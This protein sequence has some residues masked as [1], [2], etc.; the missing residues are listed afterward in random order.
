MCYQSEITSEE[1]KT[2]KHKPLSSSISPAN[3]TCLCN[4][5]FVITLHQGNEKEDLPSHHATPLKRSVLLV[6]GT[7]DF[8]PPKKI[9]PQK[10]EN[11]RKIAK[12]IQIACEYPQ[13]FH[14]TMRVHRMLRKELRRVVKRIQHYLQGE[15][16]ESGVSG[17]E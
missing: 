16:R 6:S 11:K 5:R 4:M 17:R 12:S 10:R 8:N 14:H 13:I 3:I 15:R 7:E 1:Y 9:K 2:A